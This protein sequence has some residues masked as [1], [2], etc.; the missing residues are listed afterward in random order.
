[1]CVLGNEDPIL[2]ISDRL[3]TDIGIGETVYQ[4]QDKPFVAYL[5]RGKAY[6][7]DGLKILVLGGAKSLDK[8]RRLPGITWWPNEYWTQE[9]QDGLFRLLE[10][11]NSFDLVISHT[12]PYKINKLVFYFK[13]LNH[14]DDEVAFLNDKID[15]KIQFREW[16]CGHWFS[17]DKYF[18]AVAKKKY[19]YF[20]D[21]TKIIELVGNRLMSYPGNEIVEK[22]GGK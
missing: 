13:Q 15:E 4:I 19:Q 6:T 2:G 22:R 12:G 11:V 5:K 21:T 7:I 17:D 9:E 16:L 8:K 3:E 14:F 20:F 18:D 10:T 1:L